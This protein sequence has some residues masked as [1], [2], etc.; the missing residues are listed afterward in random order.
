[1]IEVFSTARQVREFYESFSSSN[2]LLP[3]AI[4]IAEFES[5]AWILPNLIEADEDTRVLLMRQAAAFENFEKLHIPKEFMAFLQNSNYIFRFFEELANEEVDI[6]QL[7]THDTY[8]EFGEHIAI[9]KE[10]LHAYSTLLEQKGMYDSITKPK[11]AKINSSYLSSLEEV[12]IHLEGFLNRFEIRLLGECQGYC[13]VHIV[14]PITAYNKKVRSWL[15]DEGINA[16]PNSFIECDLGAKTVLKSEDLYNRRPKISYRSFSSR[17]LQA[18]FVFKKIEEFTASGILPQDIAVVLPDENFAP[19]LQEL[20]GFKNLN[21]AM[22]FGMKSSRYYQRLNSLLQAFGDDEI[23]HQHRLTRFGLSERFDLNRSTSLEEIMAFLSSFKSEKDLKDERDIIESELFLFDKFLKDAGVFTLQ[24]AAILFLQ[25]LGRQRTDDKEGGKVTVLGVLESRGARYEGV[26][27]VD[28]NDDIVPKRSGKDM[29]ISSTLR[30]RCSLPSV[31]DRENLQRF[32]YDR[33]IS[34]ARVVAICCTVNEDKLPSRFLKSLALSDEPSGELSYK[35]IIFDPNTSK[36]RAVDKIFTQ[37]YDFFQIPLSSSRLK[38]F[39]ECERRY[40]FFYIKGYK[41]PQMPSDAYD[42][43]VFGTLVHDVLKELFGQ[44]ITTI[45]ALKKAAKELVEDRR[46]KNAIWEFE[47]DIWLL[48][49]ED[50]FQNEFK[51]H[52]E[53][54]EI[55]DLE[56]KVK[57]EVGTLRLEGIIDRVDKRGDEYLLLDYKSGKVP[58]ETSEEKALASCDFQLEFYSLLYEHNASAAFYDLNSAKLIENPYSELKKEKLKEHLDTLKAQKEF[59]FDK[60]LD[61]KRCAFC[62]FDKICGSTL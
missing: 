54:W 38:H 39:L 26:I 25:R 11:I 41:E 10:L 31:E 9:L 27:I 18:A 17:A 1:M 53:G 35:D 15:A 7:D 51:R 21:F 2:T 22:G 20:D 56:R 45:A 33:L 42:A 14:T 29:F 47:S 57:R 34:N 13:R 55:L 37:E 23:E 49:L 43:R 50:F 16:K 40:Y 8:A 59:H 46:P 60:T 19:F 24:Q 62:P 48:K 32:F 28:F 3:K 44:K 36:R 30:S 61:I 58:L 5:K 12:R 52:E 4:T 6:S